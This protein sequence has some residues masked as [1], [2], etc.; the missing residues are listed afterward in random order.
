MISS[1]KKIY[2]LLLKKDK[3]KLFL[4]LLLMLSGALLEMIGI[5]SI[6]AFIYLLSQPEEIFETYSVLKPLESF[7]FDSPVSFFVFVSLLILI[8]F[9]IKNLFLSFTQLYKT[10]FSYRQQV[11]LGNK[12]LKS[13]LSAPWNFHTKRNSAETLRNVNNEI[14]VII[15][16]LLIPSLSII[17]DFLLILLT[18]ILLFFVDPFISLISLVIWIAGAVVFLYL[19]TKRLKEYGK[20]ELSLR[21]QRNKIVMQAL[22]GQKELK[23]YKKISAFLKKYNI[24]A[25]KVARAQT[26]RQM[27]T[28]LPKPFFETFAVFGI[29]LISFLLL[30]QDKSFESIL[31]LIA[32]FGAA[33]VKILPSGKQIITNITQIRYNHYAIRPVYNDLEI[34]NRDKEFEK[35]SDIAFKE[36]IELKNISFAFPD[37]KKE[38]VKNFSLKIIKGER[39]RF[40]GTS[41][42]GKSTLLEIIAGIILPQEGT[43]LVD[44]KNIR[45][46]IESWQ[47]YIGYVPQDVFLF[48]DTIENNITL[49]TQKE[50]LNKLQFQ[51]ATQIA[52]I[53][54]FIESLP[55]KEQTSIGEQGVL[56]SG[57]ERQRIGI[58]RALYQQPKLLILDEATSEIDQ[59][60]EIA[61]M[62]SLMK[63]KDLTILFAGHKQM[64]FN[65]NNQFKIVL[66]SE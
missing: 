21:K 23:L 64:A 46:N 55:D 7:Y 9:L 56:L 16:Q 19:T 40:A 8:L 10:K 27:S 45:D 65:S 34:L 22:G 47:N 25:L 41:G 20:E 57:G 12:L 66:I 30:M 61:I 49:E 36:L 17:M 6:P 52:H 48:D 42:T 33:A 44:G 43:V 3:Y 5:G 28:F 11:N 15:N 50:T 18:F 62:E 29:F 1:L 4:L 13:Y 39:Y 60:A 54:N 38:I 2:S 37:R 32:L 31:P 14:Q 24:S 59:E 26:Y 51:N 63:V 53:D 35:T 58:A